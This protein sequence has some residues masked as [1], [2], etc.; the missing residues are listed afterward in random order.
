MTL[1]SQGERLGALHS[2][3]HAVVLD[4]RNRGLRNARALR[5][6]V[7]TQALEF[8][9]DTHGLAD[10]HRYTPPSRTIVLH[11]LP[12]IVV[13]SDG[14]DVVGHVLR[15]HPIDDAP[16]VALPTRPETLPFPRQGLV[17][18]PLDQSSAVP[19]PSLPR[20]WALLDRPPART[21]Q[22]GGRSARRPRRDNR[23]LLIV[24]PIELAGRTASYLTREV[25]STSALTS[26][27]PGTLAAVWCSAR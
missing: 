9:N 19:V 10:R 24:G 1:Q 23:W 7:L 21:A 14:L 27:R 12:P 20:P 15:H 26:D 13:S 4:R 6:L 3:P 16:L 8:A 5:Q 25:I 11:L 22:L 2:Q 18:K 17:V